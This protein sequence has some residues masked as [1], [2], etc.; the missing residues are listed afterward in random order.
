MKYRA[1]FEEELTFIKSGDFVAG[2]SPAMGGGCYS[3]RSESGDIDILRHPETDMGE[4]WDNPFLYGNPILFPPNRIRGGSFRFEGREYNFPINEASTGCHI[5]GSLYRT[6]FAVDASG[7]DNISF[8]FSADK[9]EYPGFPHSF[10]IIRSYRLEGYAL[11]EKL[12]V[13]NRSE[14]NMPFM[15]AYH[16]T[17]RLPFAS[18]SERENIRLYMPVVCEHLR[19]AK[20]LPTC[21]YLYN[22]EKI[23]ALNG[24][25][26]VPCGRSVSAFYRAKN[27][28]IRLYD[29]ACGVGI[30][31]SSDKAFGYRMLWKGSD[32]GFIVTEP[33]TCAID[34]FHIDQNP[35]DSGLLVIGP[36]ETETFSSKISFENKKAN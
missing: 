20:F 8:R 30:R 16:T 25:G 36:G 23:L 13:T 3:L 5:H 17:F 33:Q 34:C 1:K 29:E 24:D 7:E 6:R 27:D 22:D 12:S 9:G 21:E 14:R 4:I 15:L 2:F 10:E 26:F 32:D 18:G 11:C 35:G 19:D 31:Y 28:P